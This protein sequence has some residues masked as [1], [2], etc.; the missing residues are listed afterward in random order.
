M[1]VPEYLFKSLI[2]S[3]MQLHQPYSWV[4]KVWLLGC[5]GVIPA[6]NSN[7]DI[8]INSGE[9]FWCLYCW[10]WLS[11]CQ[12]GEY[13]LQQG[14]PIDNQEQ[15]TGL[16]RNLYSKL[17]LLA[18]YSRLELKYLVRLGST[19]LPSKKSNLRSISSKKLKLVLTMSLEKITIGD[20]NMVRNRQEIDFW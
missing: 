14:N 19:F 13:L 7:K 16:L 20:I 6:Q 18:A 10:V 3:L 12:R 4:I 2:I 9:L 15:D 11:A 5:S 8:I 17:T 1:L